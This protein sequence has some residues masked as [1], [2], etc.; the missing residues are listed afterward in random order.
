MV[1]LS[2]FDAKAVVGV[3]YGAPDTLN[4]KRAD[5]TSTYLII[6]PS[7]DKTAPGTLSISIYVSSDFGSGYIELAPD[8]TVK[9]INYPDGVFVHRAS[10]DVA[11]CAPLCS[12]SSGA[13]YIGPILLP[14]VLKRRNG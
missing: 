8:G 7:T 5:V 13:E 2:K 3:L 1:D 9:Q 6:G 10:L 14:E 11:A 4:I 12:P